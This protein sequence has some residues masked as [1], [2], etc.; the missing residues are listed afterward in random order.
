MYAI[1]SLKYVNPRVGGSHARSAECFRSNSDRSGHGGRRHAHVPDGARHAAQGGAA[2]L[3]S[4]VGRRSRALLGAQVPQQVVPRYRGGE[5]AQR[6]PRG[7]E[8]DYRRG[9]PL[10]Q[11]GT[12]ESERSE[13]LRRRSDCRQGPV[14]EVRRL[15]REN[16]AVSARP[17]PYHDPTRNVRGG[18]VPIRCSIAQLEGTPAFV[19]TCDGRVSIFKAASL[20]FWW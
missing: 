6:A 4:E 3:R 14:S 2:I 8:R 19:A 12:R 11:P 18:D 13:A 5:H 16:G 17:A 9:A 7:Q 15:R 10:V 20:Q 1:L